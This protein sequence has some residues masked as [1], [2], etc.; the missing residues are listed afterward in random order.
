MEVHKI[1]LFRKCLI[2]YV[3]CLYIL[4]DLYFVLVAII[5]MI[6]VSYWLNITKKL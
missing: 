3:V 6:I 4:L 1:K 5:L 2:E